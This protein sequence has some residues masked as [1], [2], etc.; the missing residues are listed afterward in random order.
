MLDMMRDLVRESTRS[1]LRLCRVAGPTYTGKT[2]MD[3]IPIEKRDLPRNVCRT[4]GDLRRMVAKSGAGIV[5]V[6]CGMGA[7]S[8]GFERAT[9]ARSR[10]A[11]EAEE[12]PACVYAANRPATPVMLGDCRSFHQDE[13]AR[14]V[15]RAE[16]VVGGVPCEPFSTARLGTGA[17]DPR[18]GL[19]SY[20]VGLVKEFEPRLFA[21]ENVWGAA[22]SPQWRRAQA[23]MSRAGYGVAL[24]RLNAAEHGS[25]TTRRRAFLVGV[26][27]G[28]AE[29][30]PPAKSRPTPVREAFKGLGEPR[31]GHKDHLHQ[32]PPPMT[33]EVAAAA[34]KAG[35]GESLLRANGRNII[36]GWVLH[37]DRPASTVTT[38]P[39]IV[40]FSRRRLCTARELARIQQVP[41]SYR[42]PCS[43]REAAKV[44][45]DCVPVGL[46]EAVARA[47]D[48]RASK[49]AWPSDPSALAD[50]V[51][52]LAEAV[53][54]EE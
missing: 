46:A 33:G 22:D 41:D 8:L 21:F 51:V 48:S 31:D 42:F 14:L 30:T 37:P 25:P 35:Q 7:L 5:D 32:P 28:G 53:G 29:P 40:H 20:A 34:R 15:G 38:S 36:G 1:I 43:A 26:R 52:A 47:L 16:A 6:F 27:G 10:L 2:K 24:W 23:A 17:G 13:L 54:P 44:L 9:G 45:G 18:R 49:A 11:I 39:K 3:L 19:V 50:A 12:L 4:I